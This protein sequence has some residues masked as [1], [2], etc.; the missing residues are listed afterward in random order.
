VR[1]DRRSALIAAGAAPLALA[2]SGAAGAIPASDRHALE[3][4]LAMERRLES[5]YDAAAR[6]GVVDRVLAERLRDHEREHAEGLERALS[7][8]RRAPAARV[9]SPATAMALAAGGEEFLR[10]ALR[11]E[12]EAV[13]AYVA[14]VTRLRDPDLLQPLGSIMAAEAQHRVL[15]RGELGARLLPGAAGGVE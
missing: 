13:A 15:L 3:R 11:L 2:R 5:V 1:L 12:S 6:R 4:L 8:D 14:A 9:P 10:H 7:G